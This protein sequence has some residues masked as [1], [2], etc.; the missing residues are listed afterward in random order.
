MRCNCNIEQYKSDLTKR[1]L[2]CAFE[3]HT[4]LGSGLLESVYEQCLF[5]ELKQNGFSVEQ[6]VPLPV[7]YK[8]LFVQNAFKADLLV[9]NELIIELK[10]V[11]RILS[12]HEAQIINYMHLSKKPLGL[13]MNFKSPSLKNGI[14]RYCFGQYAG[15][16]SLNS[17]HFSSSRIIKQRTLNYVDTR[18]QRY[19]GYLPRVY[20]RA[21]DVSL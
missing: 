15:E 8:D 1:V 21:G 4:I 9:E 16:N 11:E 14:K 3:V 17:S 2:G 12:I 13:L 6:Q 7:C 5:H 20:W 10:A 19:K 18:Q